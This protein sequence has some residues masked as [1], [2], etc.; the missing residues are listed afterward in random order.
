MKK[1]SGLKPLR[2]RDITIHESTIGTSA[3]MKVTCN[4]QKARDVV[5]AYGL[6][7]AEDLNW[8]FVFL[9]EGEIKSLETLTKKF[10]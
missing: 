2:V 3:F 8:G 5:F 7:D 4:T 9:T 10:I 6:R 1:Q